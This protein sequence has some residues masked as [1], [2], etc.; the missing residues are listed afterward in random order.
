MVIEH[1]AK[2]KFPLEKFEEDLRKKKFV[3]DLEIIPFTS[4]PLYA[5]AINS[6][7]AIKAYL[8]SVLPSVFGGTLTKTIFNEE[9]MSALDRA[10]T[11]Q[12]KGTSS[13]DE[14]KPVIMVNI[15][16]KKKSNKDTETYG[17]H[18]LMNL[19]PLIGSRIYTMGN[20]E[21][22]YWDVIALVRYL[23]LIHI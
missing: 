8:G 22:E 14:R 20:P 4:K 12:C 21:S 16:K 9:S 1:N 2:G 19:F 23:S 7:I 13:T 11:A 18:V 6:Y 3:K 17:K 15:N 5:Q 10:I